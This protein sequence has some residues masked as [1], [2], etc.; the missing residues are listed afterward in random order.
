MAILMKLL[1]VLRQ[2][3]INYTYYVPENLKSNINR[4]DG[5]SFSFSPYHQIFISGNSLDYNPNDSDNGV[6][7]LQKTASNKFYYLLE[8]V[9]DYF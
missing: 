6:T 7:V 2:L 9:K 1:N 3:L 4:L 5:T 8:A